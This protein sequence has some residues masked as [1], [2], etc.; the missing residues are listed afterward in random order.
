M[1]MAI[2]EHMYIPTCTKEISPA[3][4]QATAQGVEAIQSGQMSWVCVLGVESNHPGELTTT[5]SS[6]S[7]KTLATAQ[8]KDSTISKV[9][10]YKSS[11]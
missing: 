11:H 7:T 10:E 4:I 3:T 8:R 6:I 1:P 5:A 2:D 9:I